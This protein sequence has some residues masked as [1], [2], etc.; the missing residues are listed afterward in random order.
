MWQTAEGVKKIGILS[1]LIRNRNLGHGSILF[2]DE[3]ESNLH[4]TAVMKLVEMLFQLSSAGVQVFMATHNYFV[5]KQV[6]ILARKANERVPFCSLRKTPEGTEAD[7]A[8]MR[9]GMPANPIVDA[10]IELYRRDVESE[11]EL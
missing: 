1:T 2:V 8:D 11:L 7:F 5:L 10:S 4:P 9:D 6:A 3:P